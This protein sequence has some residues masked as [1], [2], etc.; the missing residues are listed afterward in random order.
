M[1]ADVP[2]S[3]AVRP[4]ALPG[5]AER[6]PRE[7]MTLPGYYRDTRRWRLVEIRVGGGWRPAM[8]TVWRRPPGSAVWVVHV[9]WGGGDSWGW[10]CFDESSVRPLPEPQDDPPAGA[11][12]FGRWQD[13]VVVPTEL[14]GQP[15]G[16]GTDNCWRLAWVRTGGR[17]RSAVV[18]ARRRP[19]P[20]L[21]WIAH[22]R[23]G[24]DKEAAW[25]VADP[26]TVR[27]VA[28]LPNA[29]PGPDTSASAGGSSGTAEAAGT[30][31]ER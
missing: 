7:L 5:D 23:W 15:A 21:P 3:L 6:A 28:A 13:A 20:G 9:A 1:T 25:L 16:D 17:W 27:P 10:F 30:G 4:G 12:F 19:G 26:V 29:A 2:F 24:E 18:T 31:E 8:L 22:A 11:P 14:A